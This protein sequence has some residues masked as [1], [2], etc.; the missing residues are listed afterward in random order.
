MADAT[1]RIDLANVPEF[2]LGRL[3][4]RP[5][6][7]IL[8]RDDGAEEVIEPRVM[9]V[10]IALAEAQGG[11]V[12]RD[13]LI[14]R[15]WEGRVVGEDAINRVISRL[16]RTARELGDDA[17]RIETVNKVGYRLV[18]SGDAEPRRARAPRIGRRV[19]LFGGA[20]VIAAAGAAGLSLTGR[21][22]RPAVPERV[23]PF[24][25]Q[26]MTALRADNFP[27]SNQAIANLRHTVD[28]EP[29]YAD[30][31]GLLAYAY[32]MAAGWRPSRFEAELAAQLRDAADHAE[33]IE[34]GN[35]LA[36]AARAALMR[37]VGNWLAIERE[38]RAAIAQHPDNDLLLATLAKMMV[39]V[40]RCIEGAVLAERARRSAPP[41]PRTLIVRAQ[42]LW[43]AG[44]NQEAARAIDELYAL[45][46][47]DLAVWFTR[48]YQ[49]AYNGHVAEALAQAANVDGRPRDV[50]PFGFDTAIVPAKALASRTP[51]DIDAAMRLSIEGAHR[52]A[53]YAENS[54]QFA[55]A[56]GRLDTAFE[57]AE[58]YYFARGFSTGEQRFLGMKSY[59]PQNDRQT[60]ILFLPSTRAMRADARFERLVGELG[61]TH[62]WTRAG[63]VPDYRRR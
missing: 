17:F 60:H 20:A 27:G 37:R 13:A 10:L 47:N 34:P 1:C 51:A 54:I 5:P 28:L 52:G 45:F 21:R 12:T 63:V 8:A 9:Q 16:R 35:G 26:A 15:C 14:A 53:G 56:L 31:W 55:S 36:R 19:L 33:A 50:P 44:R 23:R 30:G 2:R 7:R 22:E 59:T 6:L 25:D 24:V 42:A 41:A 46:P 29:G 18:A 4:A 40:G 62:Y 3:L 39:S 11:V 61:L 58:A 43:A 48:F 38:F 49:L 57:L 32:A